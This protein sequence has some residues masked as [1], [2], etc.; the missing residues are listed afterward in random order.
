MAAHEEWVAHARADWT[1]RHLEAS[2]DEVRAT[3]LQA[4]EKVIADESP[5]GAA[6][7]WVHSTVH[8]W[9]YAMVGHEPPNQG[10]AD[11]WADRSCLWDPALALGVAG[12]VFAGQPL[13]HTG[14]Q[15]AWLSGTALAAKVLDSV[16]RSA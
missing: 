3:L 4:L 11:S 9:R 8:R 10:D 2:A 7:G 14:V 12:D 1:L 5:S 6:R 13:P 15:R 16:S